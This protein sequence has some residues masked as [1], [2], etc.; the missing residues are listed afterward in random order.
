MQKS[1]A[2]QKLRQRFSLL[3][4]C[5]EHSVKTPENNMTGEYPDGATENMRSQGFQLPIGEDNDAVKA[6]LAQ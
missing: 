3:R 2:R 6:R 1:A 4:A 5:W